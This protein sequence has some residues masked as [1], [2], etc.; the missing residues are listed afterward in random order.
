MSMGMTISEKILAMASGKSRVAPGE[1]IDTKL[2]LCMSN[3]GTTHIMIDM[4]NEQLQ[5]K[6]IFDPS[7]IVFI[8]DHNMPADSEKTA[9]VHKKM[10]EFAK[11]HKLKFHEGDGVC[12]QIMLEQYVKPGDV[13]IGADS[14]TCSYGALGAFGTGVGSTDFLYGMVTGSTW[15]MVPETLKFNIKGEFP[16]GVYARDLIFKIVGDIGANGANYKVM[17]FGGS[18]IDDF[19]IDDRIVLCNLAIEAGAKSGI[20]EPNMLVEDYLRKNRT[21]N[22]GGIYLK[23]DKDAKYFKTYQ[24]DLSDL[25]PMVARPNS[26]DDVVPVTECLGQ[27]IDQGFIGSCSNGRIEEL[28]LSAKILQGKKIH[29]NVRLIVTPASRQVY[30]QALEEG[31]LNTLSEAGAMIMNPNC[32]VCWGS[33]QGLIGK[34]EV[35][36]STGTRNFKGRCGHES[37]KVYLSSAA[38]VAVSALQGVICDPRTYL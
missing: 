32:S 25:S 18:S 33:C 27:K 37:S 6:E 38:T 31:L 1:I 12:H 11:T 13:I 7:S 21:E 23:S 8:T 2:D 35:M 20:I 36:I 14:H 17:E 10:R 24:Y 28:R 15:I 3:D 22:I 30:M 29:P 9:S 26:V 4:Y 34:D 16:E 5:K 19:T